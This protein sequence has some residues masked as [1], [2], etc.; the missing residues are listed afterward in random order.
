M[1]TMLTEE[2]IKEKLADLE[3]E[4]VDYLIDHFEEWEVWAKASKR[5]AAGEEVRRKKYLR[6]F[7]RS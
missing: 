5:V 6:R 1:R 3:Q 2:L 7:E 4:Y